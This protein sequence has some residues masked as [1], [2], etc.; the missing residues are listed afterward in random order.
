MDIVK[1]IESVLKKKGEVRVADIVTVTGFSRSYINRYFKDLKDQGRLALIGKANRARYVSAS[2][3]AVHRIKNA[4]LTYTRILKN[5][6]LSEDIILDDIRRETGIF[7]HL[8][9]NVTEI[10]GYAFTEMLNNAIEHSQ[11]DRITVK[12][13]LEND[14]IL[15]SVADRGVGIFD[16]IMKK[17]GLDSR[18]SAIQELL[19][20]KQTTA[21]HSHSGE[22]IFFTSK[23][24]DL[25]TIKSS[26]KKLIFDNRVDDLFI[27]DIKPLT[28]TTVECWIG[29]TSKRDL[30]TI[31]RQYTG[32]TS[33]FK[34]TLVTVNLYKEKFE[35]ISRSQARR[36]MSGLERF[37]TI[38]LD[39]KDVESIGQAFADEVFRVWQ[40][41]HP[42]IRIEL[43]NANENVHF[44]I[45]H[46]TG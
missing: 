26:D 29:H 25:M 19:K 40:G 14:G 6:G 4:E 37:S 36:I 43:K 12:M 42:G 17:Y 8:R 35:Y 33:E 16:N 9:R 30:Q 10:A 20:G 45:H 31:F 23:A 3:S 15:F 41:R 32:E 44:M 28:G 11:S 18:M 34:K 22:G 39:F 13:K 2:A 27:T 7:L 38:V 21:P 1:L 24:V 5:S 46:V